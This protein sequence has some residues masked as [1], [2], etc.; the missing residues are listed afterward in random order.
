MVTLQSYS[1]SKSAMIWGSIYSLQMKRL[2][3][4]FCAQTVV[5]T[6]KE[7]MKVMSCV[8]MTILIVIAVAAAAG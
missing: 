8:Y 7:R 3:W 2:S 5:T 6:H 1:F 4:F